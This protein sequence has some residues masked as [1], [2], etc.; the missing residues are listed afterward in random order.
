[1]TKILDIDVF[2]KSIIEAENIILGIIDKNER[3]NLCISATSA[4]GLVYA[5]ENMDF[6]PILN[7]FYLNLPD[8]MPC[9]WIGR[10][11]G[12]KGMQRCYGP[13]LFIEL[14]KKTTDTAIKHFFCGGKERVA[15]DLMELCKIK[16]GN[17]NIVGTFTPP[18][19]EMTDEELMELADKINIMKT[20]ILW[21]GLSTP[22]QEI[23]AFRLSKFTKVNIICTVGAAFDFHTGRMQQAPM[24]IQKIG[25]EWFFRMLMEPERLFKRYLKVVP[26]FI[27]YNIYELFRK[28][29]M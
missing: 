17:K 9:V 18:F 23:F 27:Y 21:I 10:L 25:M 8:G 11:K 26:L 19:H 20:D 24:L 7:S 1:M 5:K 28:K 16:Y 13:D 29:M 22:K 3:N 4:H 6:A 14:I 15:I 12:A 2:D